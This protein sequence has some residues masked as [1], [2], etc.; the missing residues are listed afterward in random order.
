MAW[1]VPKFAYYNGSA[2]VDF[3]PTNPATKKTP[4]G[5]KVA[6]RHDTTTSSGIKQSVYERTDEIVDMTFENVPESE[7]ASWDTMMGFLLDG[8]QF[9]FY[10]DSTN[11]LA[12]VALT[13]EDTAWE[14]KWV[15]WQ[16]YSFTLKFRKFVGTATYYS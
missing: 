12:Y 4:Y 15:S 6:T 1:I 7:M 9:D 5:P 11:Q 13:L 3:I 16:N 14:P 2:I 10:Q 8:R